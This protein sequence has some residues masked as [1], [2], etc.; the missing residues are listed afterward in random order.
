[1]PGKDR[2]FFDGHIAAFAYFGGVFPVLVYDNLTVAVHTVL[3]GKRRREQ[4]RFVSFRSYYTFEG[5]YCTPG[6]GLGR[7][8]AF[9]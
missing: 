4:E 3:R 5:R 7:L 9:A 1:M 6:K 2:M 8:E